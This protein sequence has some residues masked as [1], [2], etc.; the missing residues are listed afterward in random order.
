MWHSKQDPPAAQRADELCAYS[1]ALDDDPT[2]PKEVAQDDRS[3]VTAA[4]RAMIAAAKATR[5]HKLRERALSVGEKIAKDLDAARDHAERELQLIASAMQPAPPRDAAEATLMAQVRDR[6]A[7]M[8]A[9]ERS[10]VL[11]KADDITARAAIT[12]PSCVIGPSIDEQ[13]ARLDMHAVGYWPS[14]P[15]ATEFAPKEVTHK[16]T[17]RFLAAVRRMMH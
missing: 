9:E 10:K 5:A 13:A 8:S 17:G 6:L 1:T 16:T 2:L 15:F 12:C 4:E 7:N 11:N 14:T 3:K